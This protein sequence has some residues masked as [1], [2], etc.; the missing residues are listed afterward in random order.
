[1]ERD[2]SS[3]KKVRPKLGDAHR[4]DPAGEVSEPVERMQETDMVHDAQPD[5][6]GVSSDAQQLPEVSSSIPA[7]VSDLDSFVDIA[8]QSGFRDAIGVTTGGSEGDPSDVSTSE[9]FASALNNVP[10]AVDG[11]SSRSAAP[12]LP[13]TIDDL[14]GRPGPPVFIEQGPERRPSASDGPSI[15]LLDETTE[16]PT[17]GGTSSSTSDLVSRTQALLSPT[18]DGGPPLARPIVIVSLDEAERRKIVDEALAKSLERD[19]KLADERAEEKVSYAFWVRACEERA[20]RGD[21]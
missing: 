5:S 11:G 14:V 1:M 16:V 7:I 12:V 21:Y 15:Q 2:P 10:F 4:T 6:A 13:P 3:E 9:F 19:E 18:S 20:L 8:P 17:A